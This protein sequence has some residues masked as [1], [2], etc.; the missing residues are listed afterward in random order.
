VKKL[1]GLCREYIKPS[2]SE[3]AVLLHLS[4]GHFVTIS[5][6]PVQDCELLNLRVHAVTKRVDL[7]GYL[8]EVLAS[9]L[10]LCEDRRVLPTEQEALGYAEAVDSRA[11]AVEA[12]CCV[13]MQSR[14]AVVMCAR[15][16]RG[17]IQSCPERVDSNAFKLE[18]TIRHDLK[19]RATRTY[20]ALV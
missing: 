8:L 7:G 18:G 1:I 9:S 20:A 11:Q 16:R 19:G 3:L 15:S 17:P 5:Q 4:S 14:Q 10:G 12:D 13:P 2:L 6:I